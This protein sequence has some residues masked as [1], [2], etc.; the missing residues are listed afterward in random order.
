MNEEEYRR[1]AI[2]LVFRIKL[3]I[4][5]K[6]G[7]DSPDTLQGVVGTILIGDLLS[8]VSK[9]GRKELLKSLFVEILSLVEAMDE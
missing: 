3:M 4:H 1:L 8:G 7:A 2:E 5:E 6:V 9:D